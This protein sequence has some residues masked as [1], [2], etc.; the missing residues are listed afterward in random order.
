MEKTESVAAFYE[1]YHIAPGPDGFNAPVGPRNETG[2]FNVYRREVFRCKPTPYNRRDFYKIS[3]I[4]G[5]GTLYYADKGIQIDRPALLFSNPAIPYS[6][7]DSGE[8][9]TG[10]FCLFTESFMAGQ[11]RSES[12]QDS[13]LY[14]ISANPVFF[15]SDEQVQ[16]ISS[17]FLRMEAE[18]NSVY[19]H[20]YDVLRNYVQLIMHEAMKTQ[21]A[22][23]YFR[24]VNGAS[25]IASLFTELLERQFP[26]D[27]PQ[28][29][30][31]LK[32][33]KDYAS[34]LSVH[35]NHLNRSVK[36]TT[37][38]T[39]TDH[40]ADRIVSEARALLLH[41]DWNISEIAYTLGF[42]YPAYFNNF[43]KKR[44]SVTPGA[45]RQ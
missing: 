39:T 37:G 5:T 11:G 31:Q 18:L 34:R 4:I 35:V 26:I 28:H 38:K 36:E 9:Q 7:E 44:T 25:R 17:I 32:T 42:E 1:R 27:S 40:I 2:H 12:L 30:L 6:W 45:L 21:P 15:I 22:D 43:F 8:D 23:S 33:A 10:F 13:P 3:L 24:H 16:M 19:I 29:V 41:T 20:K 14:R